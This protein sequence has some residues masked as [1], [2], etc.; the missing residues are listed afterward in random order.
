MN[1][2]ISQKIIGILLIFFLIPTLMFLF[3]VFS[4][5][6]QKNDSVVI[7]LAGRQRMLTQKMSKES[8]TVI[9][10]EMMND[11]A[12]A[13][14]TVQSLQN[15]I[16]V[17]D[18]T[19]KALLY[20]G[21]AP[22]SLNLSGKMATLPKATG[23]V[24]TQ[25]EKVLQLWTPFRSSIERLIA[26]K[27]EEDVE[28]VLKSN[29]PLL[30]AMNAAVLLLQKQAQDK[31]TAL[32]IQQT[33]SLII[34]VIVVIL[35]IYWIRKKI[36]I[37][38]QNAKNFAAQIAAGNLT[39]NLQCDQKDE[40]GNM[41]MAL[42]H[43]NENLHAIVSKLNS[44]V[45][46]LSRSSESIENT[47]EQLKTGSE[48]TVQKSNTVA[49]AA[50]QMSANMTAIASAM[51][52]GTVNVKNISETVKEISQNI[53]HV[54]TDM[55]KGKSISAE[56]MDKIRSASCQVNALGKSA[57]EIGVVIET[58]RSISDKTNLLALNA[59]I[60]A[61]RAGEAGKGFT[62]VAN[63]IKTL[64]QQTAEAT[65]NIA[66]QLNGVQQESHNTVVQIGEVSDVM[67]RVQE[68]TTSIA[69]AV[70]LQND[71]VMEISDNVHQT[72]TGLTEINENL[73]QSSEAVNQVTVEITHVNEEA[74]EVHRS[75]EMIENN[76]V[77][78]KN[79]TQNLTDI[80]SKFKL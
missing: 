26:Q 36:I 18:K 5:N 6:K 28:I 65:E 67:E 50:E 54:T 69:D 70:G 72:A 4:T 14:K 9:H 19:L 34:G 46:H 71:A 41:V 3:T 60:E 63:E 47:S 52:E 35:F 23:K 30:K 49:A 78:L 7:N 20:S 15:T 74:G 61:A 79:L 2:K 29:L 68:I 33:A 11:N 42:N 56:A 37:P 27:Q 44:E 75:S 12:A 76:V 25:L 57:E 17:F 58:I 10:Q 21:K 66:N 51:E 80:V 8:L 77:T 59:T 32:F 24:S 64:S 45:T 1:L 13:Q 40:V 53:D 22:L 16:L 48:N 55:N 73:T 38:I 43:I 39:E 62:V 31:V